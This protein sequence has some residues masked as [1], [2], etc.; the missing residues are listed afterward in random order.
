METFDDRLRGA[1][2][3]WGRG[4]LAMRRMVVARSVLF[5][6][7]AVL[8]FGQSKTTAVLSGAIA[9]ETAHDSTEVDWVPL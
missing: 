3:L 1:K 4:R 7:G 8:A 5:T 9:A 2:S 6:L